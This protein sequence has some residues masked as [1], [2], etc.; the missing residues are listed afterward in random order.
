MNN[1]LVL[2]KYNIIFINVLMLSIK[3]KLFIRSNMKL[4]SYFDSPVMT[5]FVQQNWLP[6]SMMVL[7]GG[8]T[9]TTEKYTR[10]PF[11]QSDFSCFRKCGPVVHIAHLLGHRHAHLERHSLDS[12]LLK[13]ILCGRNSQHRRFLWQQLFLSLLMSAPPYYIVVNLVEYKK[14]QLE[15][16]LR[17]KYD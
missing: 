12:M 11:L 9:T 2:S 3:C 6:W 10:S 8:N 17:Q 7:L 13:G 16:R 5:I 4:K 14:Q 15:I 1:A